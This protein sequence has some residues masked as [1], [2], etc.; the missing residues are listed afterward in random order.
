MR[1]LA[2]FREQFSQLA[3]LN[4]NILVYCYM[5]SDMSILHISGNDTDGIFEDV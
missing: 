1:I 5:S 3:Q 2:S 4:K